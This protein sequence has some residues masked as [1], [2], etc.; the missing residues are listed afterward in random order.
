MSGQDRD[1]VQEIEGQM[2]AAEALIESLEEEVVSLRRDLEQASVALKAAQEEVAAREEALKEKEKARSAAEIKARE[3]SSSITELRIQSSNEQLDLTN[4]HIS[5]LARLQDRF[6]DQLRMEIESALSAEDREEL[7]EEHSKVRRTMEARYEERIAV[8]EDSYREAQKQLLEGEEEF[9]SRRTTE[10]EAIRNEAEEHKREREQ[11]LREQLE[12][13]LQEALRSA[14]EE[15]A[16]EL[17]TL[18]KSFAD[19]EPELLA[20]SQALAEK[21]QAEFEA[22]QAE[23]E[24]RIREAEEQHQA[25]LREIKGLAENREQELKKTHS[26]RLAEAKAEAERRI[27][28]LRAQ[29]E[30]DNKAL[31]TRHEED[32]AELRARYEGRLEET[33]EQ[34]RLELW[35]TQE[36]LE[37]LK[38]ERTAEAAA[39]R[40]RLKEL[41]AALQSKEFDGEDSEVLTQETPEPETGSLEQASSEEL[42]LLHEQVEELK[43]ALAMSERARD[44]LTQ[45]LKELQEREPE[46]DAPEPARNGHE[47]QEALEG[48]EVELRAE[49]AN[50]DER[51][52][53]LEA[54]LQE[55]RQESRRN[56]EEL[57]RAMESLR[58]LSDPEHRMRVGISAFNMSEHAR[59][60]A[61]ISKSLGL[62]K[63]HAGIDEEANKPVFTFVWEELAWR[64]YVAEPSEDIQE[65]RVYLLGGGEEPEEMAEL[66]RGPNAR[67]DAQGRLILGVQAR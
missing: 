4:Q 27:E 66:D 16:E 62:P 56:A 3:A 37:G 44:A 15:H 57:Q 13:Q 47:R 43:A 53:D 7:R 50:V 48:G 45:E 40:D 17:E 5:E 55:S 14:S 6:H 22:R 11:K 20:E 61:S 2:R 24:N 25:K 33:A 63:V 21:Q 8:L 30:A 59:H 65:P 46:E 26:A 38:L 54:R 42:D 31:R 23:L 34:S 32:L 36:K 51:V 49:A 67:I 60:V 35:T 10:I 39:Y 29:R 9:D 19:R 52:R 41:E 1:Y 12:Q 58:Q 28:S 18:R 64:R